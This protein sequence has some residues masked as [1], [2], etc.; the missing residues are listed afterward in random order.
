MKTFR[1]NSPLGKFLALAVIGLSGLA[2]EY[3]AQSLPADAPK[4]EQI[5]PGIE[6][7]QMVRQRA[8]KEDGDGPWLINALRI[9]LNLARLR[10]VHALD[11]AV[12]LET[13]SSLAARYGSVAATNAGYFRTTGTFRGESVGTLMID[14]KLLSEPNNERA[15]VGLLPNS[16]GLVFGHVRFRGILSVAGKSHKVD[17]L[18]RPVAADELVI[19]TPEFHRTTLTSPEGV[20]VVVRNKRVSAV[21]DKAGSTRIPADGYVI[22]A[23]GNSR[24]WILKHLKRGTQVILM[25]KLEP[26]ARDTSGEWSQ[27]QSITGGGPQLLKDG[28]VAI[29]N[30]AEKIGGAFV[31][32]RHPRTAI[33]KLKSGQILLLTVDGRQPGVSVGMSLPGLAELLLEFGASE[34]INLDGGGS[35]TMVVKNKIVN[36]PSDQTGERPVSDAI[37]IYPRA[38]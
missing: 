33:A 34:A 22:S 35:T 6:H 25:T 2:A 26:I 9:D 28:K 10:I 4:F 12:G 8:S 1:R 36:R 31:S 30:E 7:V 18:N 16:R 27:V 15:S 29:T 23:T 19:F 37:L 32:D 13:V 11:E 38:Q 14:R 24:S 17:G 21:S 20:E 5:A 3:R